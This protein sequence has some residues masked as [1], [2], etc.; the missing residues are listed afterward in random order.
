MLCFRK[1]P[2]AKILKVREGEYQG[3][4][5]KSFCLTVPKIFAGET[6]CAVFQENSGSEKFMD[7]RGWISRFSV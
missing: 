5:S 1:F 2:V 7:T 3:F 4:P 6:F